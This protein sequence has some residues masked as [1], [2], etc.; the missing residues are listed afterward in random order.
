MMDFAV[1]PGAV[2]CYA[3][4]RGRMKCDEK[5][6]VTDTPIRN[7]SGVIVVDQKAPLF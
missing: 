2:K 5:A 7:L 1:P 4:L 6:A 3:C